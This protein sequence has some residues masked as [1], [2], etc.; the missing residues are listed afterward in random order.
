MVIKVLIE[1]LVSIGE[2]KVASAEG[3]KVGLMCLRQTLIYDCVDKLV[4][5]K[6]RTDWL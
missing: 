2:K 3:Q 6:K 1:I 5:K 4:W